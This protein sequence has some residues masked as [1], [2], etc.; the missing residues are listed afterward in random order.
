MVAPCMKTDLRLSTMQLSI[1]INLKSPFIPAHTL[2]VIVDGAGEAQVN[3]IRFYMPTNISSCDPISRF[4]E[5][6]CPASKIRGV[7]ARWQYSIRCPLAVNYVGSSWI[8][9]MHAGPTIIARRSRTVT[10]DWA[11]RLL[12]R[13]HLAV[14]CDLDA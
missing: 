4:E 1:E 9:G 11:N 6:T 2:R 7:H 12:T 13:H 8:A 3:G 14:D 10:V 5:R